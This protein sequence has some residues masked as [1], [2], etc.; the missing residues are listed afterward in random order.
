MSKSSLHVVL[1]LV[2][3]LMHIYNK[4]IG[5]IEVPLLNNANCKA[6]S[7]YSSDP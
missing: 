2:S 1:P 7:L 5:G 3:K 6:C 4:A